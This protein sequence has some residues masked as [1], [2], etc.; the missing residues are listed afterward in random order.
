M[1]EGDFGSGGVVLIIVHRTHA[2][3]SPLHFEIAGMPPPG[4]WRILGRCG[5]E[6]LHLAADRA[7]ADAWLKKNQHS[8]ARIEP[9]GSV[10]D[11]FAAASR[12]A[13]GLAG[14]AQE[15]M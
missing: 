6:L 11:E 14:S 5:V 3:D 8:D 4:A 2:L 15:V 10:G 7:A 1:H 9:V 12:D 13:D